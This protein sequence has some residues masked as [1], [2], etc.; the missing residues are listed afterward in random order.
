MPSLTRPPQQNNPQR[1]DPL[2]TTRLT[3]RERA[4]LAR[5]REYLWIRKQGQ[6]APSKQ[7]Q[8]VG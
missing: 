7:E 1:S 4:A 3:S 2:K 8:R 5:L 6:P